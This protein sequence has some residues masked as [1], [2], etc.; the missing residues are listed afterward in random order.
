MLRTHGLVADRA[1]GPLETAVARRLVVLSIPA[2]AQRLSN[3]NPAAGDAWRDGAAHF[4]EHCAVCHG[5]DGRGRSEIGPKMYP[6]VP[7]LSSPGIQA[8]SDGALFA[9]IQNGVRWTGMPAFRSE[10]T[11]EETW[12]LVSFV[13]RV[14]RLTA[15][16]LESHHAEADAQPQTGATVT[17]DGTAFAPATFTV[18]LGDTVTWMNKDPFPHN[19]TS[20]SGGFRSKD[21]APDAQWKFR[22]TRAGTFRY[23]CTLHPGMEGTLVV[24]R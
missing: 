6:P 19:V 1:P 17:M 21:L 5:Q 13:R 8:M 23:V 3:P 16:D 7:D 18:K 11:P 12:K 9:V 15:A 4:Q 10:H 2:S 14:P 24:S 20:S 22:T